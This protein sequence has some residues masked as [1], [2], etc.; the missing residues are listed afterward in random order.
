MEGTVEVG[1]RGVRRIEAGHLW[2]YRSD[3][4]RTEA[5]TPGAVVRVV[6]GRGWLIGRAFYSQT[7]EITL[8]LLNRGDEAV[9]EA[10]FARR[11]DAALALRRR[12]FGSEVQALRLVHGEADLLP[13]LVVDRYGDVLVVQTL[14]QGSDRHQALFLKLLR[15]RLEPRAIVLRNDAKVRSHEGLALKREV[16]WGS[17]E[18]PVTYAEDGLSLLSDPVGGQKTGAF[19]DQRE[20]RQAV[21][22]YV[23][24]GMVCADCFSYTG[25]FA[26][27]MA[28]AGGIVTAVDISEKALEEAREAG[29]RNGLE[30]EWTGANAFDWLKERSLE[31]EAFDLVVLDPPAFARR[32]EKLE[33]ALRGYKEINLRALQ[34]L[35]PG[36]LLVS[37]SCSYHVSEERLLA[38]VLSAAMDAGRRLQLLE[39]R[40][41]GRDHPVLLGVPE[42]GYLKTLIFRVVD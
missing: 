7:S 35:R 28:R 11:I 30:I 5:V 12:L 18:G 23:E 26:L 6:D 19:L 24:P 27:H 38:T 4:Q 20:N 32:K 13:G 39:R 8:R 41:A 3:V 25:G 21:A 31:G 16:V 37:C 9:D 40:G 2:I 15:E 36:G 42:T 10:F 17:L 34:I 22:R 1:K 33:G 29:E 14:S